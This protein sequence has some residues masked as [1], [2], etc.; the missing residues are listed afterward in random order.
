MFNYTFNNETS[1]VLKSTTSKVIISGIP[2]LFFWMC[3]EFHESH[4]D[5]YYHYI[6]MPL[7]TGVIVTRLSAQLSG[8][9]VKGYNVCTTARALEEFEPMIREGTALNGSSAC[10]EPLIG[11]NY[12]DYIT[13]SGT[14]DCST[15]YTGYLE[16]CFDQNKTRLDVVTNTSCTANPFSTTGKQLNCLFTIPIGNETSDKYITML[17]N[18]DKG[19]ASPF[20]CMFLDGLDNSTRSKASVAPGTCVLGQN[21]SVVPTSGFRLELYTNDTCNGAQQ[22]QA[23]PFCTSVCMMTFAVLKFVVLTPL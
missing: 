22:N 1:Y 13:T 9:D 11:T 5:A 10:P 20:F 23:P 8:A 4:A 21:A 18:M 17:Y 16:S 14:K 6:N 3:I 12:F 2:A 19:A 7:G 15:N